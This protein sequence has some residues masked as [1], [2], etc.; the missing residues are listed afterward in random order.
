MRQTCQ[1]WA[2]ESKVRCR[3]DVNKKRYDTVTF[4]IGEREF[5]ALVRVTL[6]SSV[7]DSNICQI[8]SQSLN[9]GNTFQSQLHV[10][11]DAVQECHAGQARKNP[12][13]ANLH[14]A[15]QGWVLEQCCE[16]LR[17]LLDDMFPGERVQ[18]PDVPCMSSDTM[19]QTFGT[20]VEFAYTGSA[21]VPAAQLPACWALASGFE[22]DA[23]KVCQCT[24]PRMTAASTC[25]WL[26]LPICTVA[27]RVFMRMITC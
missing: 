20:L 24:L 2:A 10:K 17:P 12:D 7:H 4:L 5:Y 26:S 3:S 22:F 25:V 16:G 1:D 15:M 23:F 27:F 18:L 14:F 19:Y 6:A 21:D 11:A 9:C 8:L 13:F